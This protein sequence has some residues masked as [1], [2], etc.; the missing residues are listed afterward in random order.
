MPA[1]M[2]IENNGRIDMNVIEVNAIG[3]PCP[4]PMVM[5]KKVFSEAGKAGVVVFVDNEAA[6]DNVVKM[7]EKGGFK[8]KTYHKT[9]KGFKVEIKKGLLSKKKKAEKQRKLYQKKKLCTC[10]NLIL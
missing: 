10:L 6:K 9:K 2:E 4:Q 7:A 1:G 3:K 5:T 8:V